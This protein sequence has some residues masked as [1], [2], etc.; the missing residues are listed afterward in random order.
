MGKRWPKPAN[1]VSMQWSRELAY[2]LGLIASDGCLSG[3]GRHV[4]F[5]SK[6]KD[7]VA[8]FKKCLRLHNK[9]GKKSRARE[10][11]K[12]YYRVQ[13]GDVTFYAFLVSIGFM[14]A[15]SKKLGILKIPFLYFSDF[16]RGCIDGDG[17]ITSFRHPESQYLQIR[18]RVV[19]ASL[20]F[21]RWIQET[22]KHLVEV[23]GGW[24]ENS[25]KISVL[26]Y[27]TADALKI[28]RF[29]YYSEKVPSLRRKR[30]RAESFMR[31]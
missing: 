21:L 5:N 7:L 13:F 9:I 28:F 11:I 30:L 10:K 20:V 16:L 2:A 15:K 19:S 29:I 17:S 24:I 12:K 18:L 26:T 6:D 8:Q 25:P 23:D 31:V 22:V 27:A 4:E 1:R 14:P 3:D